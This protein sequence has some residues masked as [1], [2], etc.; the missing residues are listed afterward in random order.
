[1]KLD[2]SEDVLG[3]GR[4]D[5]TSGTCTLLSRKV[6]MAS[7]AANIEN[8]LSESELRLRRIAHVDKYDLKWIHENDIGVPKLSKN[9]GCCRAFE[10]GKEHNQPFNKSFYSTSNIGEI[11]HSGVLGK[12]KISFLDRQYFCTIWNAYSRYTS[13]GLL[14]NRR[15]LQEAF[16]IMRRKLNHIGNSKC[17]LLF[18]GKIYE[19]HSDA[20]AYKILNDDSPTEDMKSNFYPL[21]KPELIEIAERDN[22][23]LMVARTLLTQSSLPNCLWPFSLKHS[24]YIQNKLP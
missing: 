18:T 10:L 17:T 19:I 7:S 21:Y 11:V 1:M 13:L 6:Q 15:D 23:A 20:K 3:A 22:R 4:C 5:M 9:L 12:L 24:A 2:F 8:F 14:H 16:T